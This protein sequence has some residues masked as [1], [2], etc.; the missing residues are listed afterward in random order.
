VVNGGLGLIDAVK[1]AIVQWLESDAKAADHAIRLEQEGHVPSQGNQNRE[2]LA[3]MVEATRVSA[4]MAAES[5][6][7]CKV[8]QQI[9]LDLRAK[10]QD[11]EFCKLCPEGSAKVAQTRW[12]VLGE[13]QHRDLRDA[14]RKAAKEIQE[15]AR[16]LFLKRIKDRSG[17]LPNWELLYAITAEDKW[18]WPESEQGVNAKA[19]WQESHWWGLWGPKRMDEWADAYLEEYKAPV[20]D[21]AWSTLLRVLQQLGWAALAQCGKTKQRQLRPNK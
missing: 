4:T 20:S 8:E 17:R 9:L 10:L 7:R 1:T 2:Q 13:C 19:G 18:I 6:S 16:G 14:R 12:R 15:T 21:R 5:A 3:A 11:T